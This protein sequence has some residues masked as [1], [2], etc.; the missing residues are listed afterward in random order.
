[1]SAQWTQSTAIP[2]VVAV[3]QVVG[4]KQRRCLSAVQQFH[5]ERQDWG[6]ALRR[7]RSLRRTPLLRKERTT[8]RKT[9]VAMSGSDARIAAL[10]SQP[11]A[12]RIIPRRGVL[13][14]ATPRRMECRGLVMLLHG[15]TAMMMTMLQVTYRVEVAPH[16]EA[17]R[18][19]SNQRCG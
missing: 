1:M 18:L 11:S 19:S 12:L 16:D 9:T 7:S 4:E 13:Q 15:G 5:D 17:Q 10:Q 14:S 2:E 8:T 6:D 3:E